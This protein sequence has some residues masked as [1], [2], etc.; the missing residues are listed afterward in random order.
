MSGDVFEVATAA[1]LVVEKMLNQQRLADGS[2][3]YLLQ[4]V[5][6]ELSDL[7]MLSEKRPFILV[8]VSGTTSHLVRQSCC[9]N[10]V[11]Q[12]RVA[13]AYSTGCATGYLEFIGVN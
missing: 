11:E 4:M 5:A 8:D 6:D 3:G 2:V 7:L 10:R 9:R 13:H 1:Y 12:F